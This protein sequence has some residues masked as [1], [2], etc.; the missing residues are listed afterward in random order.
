MRMIVLA[1]SLAKMGNTRSNMDTTVLCGGRV[2]RKRDAPT[3]TPRKKC[4][5]R[6]GKVNSHLGKTISYGNFGPLFYELLVDEV[7]LAKFPLNI[8]F[9]NIK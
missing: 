3:K 1:R 2:L 7:C 9:N 5:R 6:C 4:E 8:N